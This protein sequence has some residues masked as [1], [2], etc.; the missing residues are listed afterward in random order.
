M[1]HPTV[2]WTTRRLSF[3]PTPLSSTTATAPACETCAPFSTRGLRSPPGPMIHFVQSLPS[4]RYCRCSA[5]CS[6]RRLPLYVSLHF[7]SPA[8]HKQSNNRSCFSCTPVPVVQQEQTFR[9]SLP[10]LS[11]PLHAGRYTTQRPTSPS[12]RTDHQWTLLPYMFLSGRI[13]YAIYR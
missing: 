2:P 4:A 12:L 5:P 1:V 10:R 7:H 6:P 3:S 11:P 13:L 8:T 9:T